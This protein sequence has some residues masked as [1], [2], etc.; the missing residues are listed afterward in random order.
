MVRKSIH[1]TRE[2]FE[3]FFHGKLEAELQQRMA[4]HLEE[5][6]FCAEVAEVWQKYVSLMAENW[7]NAQS[8]LV[9][10]TH[11][12]SKWSGRQFQLVPE[13]VL[14]QPSY[15][16]AADA[17]ADPKLPV[18]HLAT[19]INQEPEILL[20]VMR[21]NR[22]Q[23]SYFHVASADRSL[24]DSVLIQSTKLG[25]AYLTDCHGRADISGITDT[26]F[27][28]ADWSVKV[29]QA[30]FNLTPASSNATL[31]DQVDEATLQNERGDK[32]RISLESNSGAKQLRLEILS[33]EGVQ[34]ESPLI[35][36]ISVDHQTTTH[37]ASLSRPV[38]FSLDSIPA[39]LQIRIFR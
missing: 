5:C 19:L 32:I 20:R 21:D 14:P 11:S 15:G 6:E 33:L 2:E 28:T 38:I 1:P 4:S 36:S 10:D 24:C 29:P 25:K 34:D 23:Q 31:A 18:E 12:R 39:E 8:L 26:D 7:P 9:T 27:S 35:A 16:I 30:E 37:P 3:K 17:Q 22:S 13:F